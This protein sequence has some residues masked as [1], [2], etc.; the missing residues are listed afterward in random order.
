[1]PIITVMPSSVLCSKETQ[2]NVSASAATKQSSRDFLDA[3]QLA[4]VQKNKNKVE[5]TTMKI[6]ETCKDWSIKHKEEKK[7][8]KMCTAFSHLWQ[9]HDNLQVIAKPAKRTIDVH[10]YT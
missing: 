3:Q 8:R 1:M 6:S 2:E 9:F 10:T 5:E 7:K 4:K